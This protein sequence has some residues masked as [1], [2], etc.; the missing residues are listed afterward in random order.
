[1]HG[2]RITEL[3]LL[4]EGDEFII[5][6]SNQISRYSLTGK[7]LGEADDGL[8]SQYNYIGGFT[9]GTNRIYAAISSTRTIH[10]WDFNL[11]HLGSFSI[12]APAPDISG[13]GYNKGKLYLLVNHKSDD[14]FQ[15]QPITVTEFDNPTSTLSLPDVAG[16]V[17]GADYYDDIGVLEQTTINNVNAT[18][19]NLYDRT[20]TKKSRNSVIN[21]QHID[22]LAS[23]YDTSAQVVKW[24][25]H[26]ATSIYTFQIEPFVGN[27][28]Y[29]VSNKE[30]GGSVSRSRGHRWYRLFTSSRQVVR[31]F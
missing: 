21:T 20:G 13:L 9:I 26:D 25:G 30:S 31:I 19:L 7:K 5:L 6:S 12:N 3:V 28:A 23:W 16:T 17:V 8:G 27:T 24:Y 11:K 15:I 18:W 1:M 2:I 29:T 10:Y 4:D 14:H 22:D